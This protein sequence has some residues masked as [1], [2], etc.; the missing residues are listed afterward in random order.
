MKVG[1][2]IVKVSRMDSVLQKK[3]LGKIFTLREQ[4]IIRGAK[5]PSEAA[6]SYFAA[7]EAL[8]KAL[9]IGIWKMG[10][11]SVEIRHNDLGKP[12][13]HILDHK[14]IP[15][16]E[17]KIDLSITHDGGHCIA[18][19]I[20]EDSESILI[21]ENILKMLKN[22]NEDSHKGDYGKVAVIGG[23][24]GMSGSSY[25]S[26]MAA[27]RMGSGLCYTVAPQS[28]SD[29][30]QIKSLENIVLPIATGGSDF[31]VKSLF[32]VLSKIEK[33]D[34]IA[35]GPGLGNNEGLYDFVKGI[36]NGRKCAQIIDA[37]GL[38]AL[39]HDPSILKYNQQEIIITPH[40][41]EMARLVKMS[42]SEVIENRI[43]IAKSF[44]KE[45]NIVVLLKGHRTIIT[46]GEKV[47][48]NST[49]NSGMAT[50]GSGDVLTGMI[51]SLLG[52][53]YPALEAGR[54]GAYIHGLSGDFMAR[55]LGEDGLIA[56][57]LI[58]GLPTVL[59]LMR[60]RKK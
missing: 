4:E 50:A 34:A 11:N 45:H 1:I 5:Y 12:Y 38:N 15:F 2:D 57:D 9:G 47:Y 26:S 8:S 39:S 19:C 51:L 29:I 60:E 46:D 49:G 55:K 59:K 30:L 43:E 27:L 17:E 6:S 44:A 21:D 10:L 20:L 28:I 56:S 16:M 58:K 42:V 24:T 13:Y 40:P 41:L 18:V 52:Q 53:G 48:F 32:E 7:K 54:L 37:D 23:S 3:N 25:L 36:L 35:V 14:R 22:R 31:S 33:M